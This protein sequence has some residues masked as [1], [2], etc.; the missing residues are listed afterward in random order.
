MAIQA[1]PPWAF[2]WISSGSSTATAAAAP[3][4][5]HTGPRPARSRSSSQPASGAIRKPANQWV[6]NAAAHTDAQAA[7]RN[8]VGDSTA[9]TRQSRDS[10][11]RK[12]SSAYGRASCE[13]QKRTGLTAISA[14]ATSPTRRELVARPSS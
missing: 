4:T 5:A 6:A 13:Y 8:G 2:W 12:T 7:S 10:A 3:V 11:A 1:A 9:R 14:P